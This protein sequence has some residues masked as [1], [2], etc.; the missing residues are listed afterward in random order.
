MDKQLTPKA[1]EVLLTTLYAPGQVGADARKAWQQMGP[2]SPRE[3]A[4]LARAWKR[5]EAKHRENYTCPA[6]IVDHDGQV[7]WEGNV[8]VGYCT[9]QK[10]C[11]LPR[12]P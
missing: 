1:R 11:D 8:T 7:C 5:L 12:A 6:V 2:Q 10:L 9:L 3:Q 4:A